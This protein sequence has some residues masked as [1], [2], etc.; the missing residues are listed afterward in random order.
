MKTNI[1]HKYTASNL[2]EKWFHSYINSLTK[3]L[4]PLEDPPVGKLDPS[5][6]NEKLTRIFYK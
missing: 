3:L 6:S 1:N 2:F 5:H 4:Y